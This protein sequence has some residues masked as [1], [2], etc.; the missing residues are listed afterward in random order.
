M[1]YEIGDDPQGLPDQPDG[2]RD[3]GLRE[4]GIAAG[5]NAPAKQADRHDEDAAIRQFGEV[6]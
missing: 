1:E 3:G 4:G 5:K 6:A 2:D